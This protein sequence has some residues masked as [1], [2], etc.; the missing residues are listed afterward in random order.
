MTSPQS[1]GRLPAEALRPYSHLRNKVASTRKCLQPQTPW[2]VEIFQFN[3]V[4]L[5]PSLNILSY[6]YFLFVLELPFAFCFLLDVDF[7]IH[8]FKALVLQRNVPVP[9]KLSTGYAMCL[10]TTIKTW[11]SCGCTTSFT[12]FPTEQ[13]LFS[14]PW[15]TGS[16]KSQVSPILDSYLLSPV[17]PHSVWWASSNP[18]RAWI[19]QKKWRKENSSLLLPAC[20]LE[21]R[22]QAP[23]ILGLGLIPL[24]PLVFRPSELDFNY[25]NSFSGSPAWRQQI[26]GLLSLHNLIIPHNKF[27]SIYK[28]WVL[29]L[30]RALTN[31]RI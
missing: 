5:F 2:I 14:P 1:K 25:T 31:I 7:L 22:H 28:L 8:C 16:T 15:V 24:A 12:N 9:L 19:E 13:L 26:M 4:I 11:F 3:F 21:L 10:L 29:F 17:A 6:P 18:L 30:W 23:P 27:I 20:L